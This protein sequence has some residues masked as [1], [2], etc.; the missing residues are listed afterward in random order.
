MP[1]AI[2]GEWRMAGK[3]RTIPL[4][5][6]ALL[7]C[8]ASSAA[9][10][11]ARYRVEVLVF[12]HVDANATAEPVDALRD[13]HHAY[14]LDEQQPPEVPLPATNAGQTFANLWA[15]LQRLQAYE[16]LAMAAWEQSQVDFHP[17]VRIHDEE[18]IA[19]RLRLP[20]EVFWLDL[21]GRPLFAD[22]VHTLY[23]LDGSAQLRRSRFLHIDLDL[24]YRVDDP[25]AGMD[26]RSPAAAAAEPYRI[27][28]LRQSRLVKTGEV[29]YFDTAWLGALVRVTPIGDP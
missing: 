21:A 4:L 15:R 12:R 7:A 5:T 19:E 23:R 17:P 6:L 13:F 10:A 26:G 1:A 14:R 24:E 20:G 16:P 11:E 2:T 3:P 8:V 29:H 27:H 9:S 18:I 28:H 25:Q 22:Y